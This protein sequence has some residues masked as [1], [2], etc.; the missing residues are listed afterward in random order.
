MCNSWRNMFAAAFVVSGVF[1]AF[2][3]PAA[4]S[5]PPRALGAFKSWQAYKYVG[6]DGVICYAT[7]QPDS[8]QGEVAGR[9]PRALFVTENPG[10]GR[11][12]ELNIVLGFQPKPGVPVT[13][14]AGGS[15]FNLT[16]TAG[17]RV[18]SA[19]EARDKEIVA[20][21]RAAN[22][23]SVDAL[24]QHG[25]PVQDRYNLGGFSKAYQAA[26]DACREE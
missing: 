13:L 25:I 19:G 10:G 24:S 2:P 15:T 3:A 26:Q 8:S 17:D 22:A 23:L 16:V 14:K 7:S 18:W 12:G 20:A 1:T 5:A 21:L 6:E 11:R 4:D 9:G